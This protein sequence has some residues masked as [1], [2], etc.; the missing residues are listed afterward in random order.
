MPVRDMCGTPGYVAPEVLNPKLTGRR[1]RTCAQ[2]MFARVLQRVVDKS[3]RSVQVL[4]VCL[5]VCSSALLTSFLQVDA[6]FFAGDVVIDG[7]LM[8]VSASC[9]LARLYMPV[10]LECE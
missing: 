6:L 4:C 7:T 1:L 3:L 5:C 2:C 8:K 10:L 9:L